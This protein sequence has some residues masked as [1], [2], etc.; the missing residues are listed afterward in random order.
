MLEAAVLAAILLFFPLL[1]RDP[2]LATVAF[3]LAVAVCAPLARMARTNAP[4]FVPTRRADV[5]AMM[6][7]AAIRKGERA[8]DLGCG[9]GRIVRAAAR[10]GAVATGYELSVPT[11][12]LAKILCLGR[13]NAR[14]AYG[15]F[16]RRDFRDADVVFCFLLKESMS[17][18]ERTIWP[19]LKP[20]TRVLS[21]MFKLPS[22]AE[23]ERQGNVR[24]YVK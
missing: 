21:V 11:Y 7:M 6:R 5:D 4:P 10:E 14:V 8:Y 17:R 13:K 16:W 24:L 9:D 18:F 3:A 19:T 15:D 1:E 23:T 2:L 20:G 22:R 12:V